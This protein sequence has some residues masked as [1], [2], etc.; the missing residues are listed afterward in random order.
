MISY[1]DR[2]ALCTISFGNS[3]FEVTYVQ[4]GKEVDDSTIWPGPD[5]YRKL[6][7]AAPYDRFIV[8]HSINATST[9]G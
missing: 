9:K 7:K 2:E 6:L 1:T 5:P 8:I 3:E 4:I